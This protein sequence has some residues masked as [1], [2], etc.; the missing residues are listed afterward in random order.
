M[1]SLSWNHPLSSLINDYDD[2]NI[3]MIMI[4]IMKMVKIG[5]TWNQPLLVPSMQWAAQTMCKLRHHPNHH[6]VRGDDDGG[7]D[8][9][10]DADVDSNNGVNKTDNNGDEDMGNDSDADD[11]YQQL[12]LR[13]CGSGVAKCRGTWGGGSVIFLL[14]IIIRARSDPFS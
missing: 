10:D 7:D 8:G 2:D 12:W 13:I 9:G 3:I 11:T 6:A 1:I 5:L 4:I 14:E